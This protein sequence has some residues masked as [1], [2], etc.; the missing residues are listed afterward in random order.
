LR[1]MM[2]KDFFDS[3][4]QSRQCSDRAEDFYLTPQSQHLRFYQYTPETHTGS[5]NLEI[6]H[7]VFQSPRILNRPFPSTSEPV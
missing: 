5:R 2:Q 6:G 3:I 7:R 4:G 1:P